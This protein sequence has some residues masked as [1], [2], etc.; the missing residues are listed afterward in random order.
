MEADENYF[1]LNME[2]NCIHNQCLRAI[3][4]HRL[5]NMPRAEYAPSPVASLADTEPG[6]CCI[7]L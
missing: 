4:M 1:V 2:V 3:L 6:A 5:W 7:I